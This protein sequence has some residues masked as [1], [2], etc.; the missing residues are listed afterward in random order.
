M[1][2]MK[3]P[4][5]KTVRRKMH[6]RFVAENTSFL[7]IEAQGINIADYRIYIDGNIHGTAVFDEKPT[8]GQYIRLPPKEHKVVVRDADVNKPDRK[9]SNTMCF[10]L[11]DKQELK[12]IIELQNNNLVLSASS[13]NK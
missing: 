5:E 10:T 1:E 6:E 13:A 2:A 8:N 11:S 12:L 3:E 9:E 4:R 7:C